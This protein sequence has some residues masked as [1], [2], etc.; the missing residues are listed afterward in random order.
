MFISISFQ[1]DYARWQ[2]ML[3]KLLGFIYIQILKLTTVE[4]REIAL[5]PKVTQLTNRRR[6]TPH[7]GWNHWNKLHYWIT[8]NSPNNLLKKNSW[9]LIIYQS[10]FLMWLIL[11]G[12]LIFSSMVIPNIFYISHKTITC[13]HS[14]SILSFYYLYTLHW[15]L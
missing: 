15:I 7:K 5:L 3:L 10:L 11:G 4:Y 12:E 2:R 13:R 6:R 14:M 8:L 9:V 1:N